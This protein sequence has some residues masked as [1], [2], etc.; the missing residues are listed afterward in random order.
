[1]S[2]LNIVEYVSQQESLFLPVVSDESVVWEKEKQFAIQALMS[3]DYL[4]KIADR[5]SVV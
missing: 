4:A 3:N 2:N 1:M 5:K